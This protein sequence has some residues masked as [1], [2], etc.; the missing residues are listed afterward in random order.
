MNHL[1]RQSHT[2][3]VAAPFRNIDLTWV[4]CAALAI[5]LSVQGCANHPVPPPV[6]TKSEHTAGQ[7]TGQQPNEKP[8][9]PT[10]QTRQ[11]DP[12]LLATEALMNSGKYTEVIKVLR[13]ALIRRPDDP[14]LLA[15]LGVALARTGQNEEALAVLGKARKGGISGAPLYNELGII[16]RHLGRLDDARKAYLK[17]L[18]INPRH[19]PALRNLGILLEL[20]LQRPE[21]ATARYLA[22]LEL[23]PDSKEIRLWLKDIEQRSMEPHL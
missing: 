10:V 14:L 3:A 15:N 11:P 23:Q 18:E 22:Y 9:V 21:M 1:F 7:I 8:A 17:A 19:L 2:E 4:W 12:A 13:T 16:Y 6:S 20:Y 5:I